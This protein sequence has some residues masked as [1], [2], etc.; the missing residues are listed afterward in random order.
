MYNE[1]YRQVHWLKIKYC[2]EKH[3]KKFKKEMYK[4]MAAFYYVL[5]YVL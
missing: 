5:F 1:K 2:S 4:G 3:M